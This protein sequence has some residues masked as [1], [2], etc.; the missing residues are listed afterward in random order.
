MAPLIWLIDTLVPGLSL[1]YGKLDF[2]GKILI[3]SEQLWSILKD[4]EVRS[5][6]IGPGFLFG[7][8]IIKGYP[9]KIKEPIISVIL[10]ATELRP[11]MQV[12]LLDLMQPDIIDPTSKANTQEVVGK[13]RKIFRGRGQVLFERKL[14]EITFKANIPVLIGEEEVESKITVKTLSGQ[15]IMRFL[16]AGGNHEIYSK[17]IDYIRENKFD[18]NMNLLR[19]DQKNIRPINEYTDLDDWI[20]VEK[21][22]EID[23]Q[24]QYKFTDE[25][26]KE[27]ARVI[28]EI[29][30]NQSCYFIE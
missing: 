21:T 3:I 14:S 2:K 23:P 18:N 25:V 5:M 19:S 13:I 7:E 6:L 1:N 17:L 24:K 28:G 12:P 8:A 22:T 26:L 4:S 11:D 30:D 27:F 15:S 10:D 16:L 9:V 20:I 29:K